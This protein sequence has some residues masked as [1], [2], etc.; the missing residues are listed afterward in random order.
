MKN[1]TCFFSAIIILFFSLLP[2]QA[3]KTTEYLQYAD[4]KVTLDIYNP[5]GSSCAVAVLIHG[6]AGISGD[7]AVR[8]QNFATDLMKNGIIAINVHYFDSKQNNWVDTIRNTIS[9]VQKIPNADINRIGL[10]GY[11]FGGIL[12]L[13]VASIDNRVKL[14]ATSAGFLPANFTKEDALRLPKILMIS[15]DQDSAMITLNTLRQWLSEEGRPFEVKIDKGLG[16]DNIP[17]NVFQQ[18]WQT[19]LRFFVKNL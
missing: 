7:R 6:A 19:I 9:Y 17:M 5:G 11:S 1:I 13:K 16:H 8:Y 2:A 4:E 15:G 18:D 14:L 10:I 3:E 12:A